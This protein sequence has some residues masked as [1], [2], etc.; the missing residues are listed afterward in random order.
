LTLFTRNF[1]TSSDIETTRLEFD[2]T[3]ELDIIGFDYSDAFLLFETIVN[4]SHS[5][6]GLQVRVSSLPTAMSINDILSTDIVS[7]KVVPGSQNNLTLVFINIKVTRPEGF[8]L[9]EPDFATQINM[10]LDISVE[11]LPPLEFDVRKKFMLTAFHPIE[12]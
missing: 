5:P 4:S 8:H 1:T 2:I 6:S 10:T 11:N 12:F 9:Q 3:K 7:A